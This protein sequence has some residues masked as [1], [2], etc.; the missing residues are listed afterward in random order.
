[1]GLTFPRQPVVEF[2]L[3]DRWRDVSLDVR[4]KPAIT[5]TQGR[6]DWAAK[7]SPAS[8]KF[9]LDDGPGH[10]DGDYDP[11]NPLGQWFGSFTR[12]VPVR[13]ALRYGADDFDRAVAAGWGT[14]PDMGAWTR[15][16]SAPANV[17]TDVNGNG[18][19]LVSTAA[20][21]VAQYLNDVSQKDID[22]AVNFA[23]NVATVTGGDLEP[24]NIMVRGQHGTL[25]DYYLVRCTINTSNQ[26]QLRIMSR[27]SVTLVGPVTVQS[28]FDGVAYTIRV[29]ADGDTLRTKLWP[30]L[31]GEPL[32]WDLEYSL[33]AA[34]T[35]FGA[36]W[37]GIR[38]GVGGGNTNTKPIIVNY[39]NLDVR[40]PRFAGETVKLQPSTTVDHADRTTS[41]EAAAIRRRLAK[42]EKPLFTA[43]RRYIE[44]GQAPFLVR[45][46]W[47]MDQDANSATRASDVLGGPDAR[48]IRGPVSG[49]GAFEY[50]FDTTFPAC[51]KAAQLSTDG[52]LAMVIEPTLFSTSSGW[53][54]TW[55]QKVGPN[56]K[57][58]VTV[59]LTNGT[60]LQIQFEGGVATMFVDAVTAFSVDLPEDGDDSSWHLIGV[61]TKQE[62]GD[63]KK[64]LAVDDRLGESEVAGTTGLP[65]QFAVFADDADNSTVQLSQVVVG[66]QYLFNFP[67]G[68]FN[69]TAIQ[70]L[71]LGRPGETAGTRLE[72]LTDEEGIADTL[73]GAATDTPAMGP[74]T[75]LPLLKLLD[76]CVTVDQGSAFDPR[77]TTGL[78][79]RTLRSTVTRDPV[80]TL[81]Y[82]SG[83]VAPD[84]GPITDDQPL[85]ND[86]TAKRP[87][88]GEVQVEQDEGPNN[89]NDPGTA[90]GAAGRA[91][92]SVT[93]NVETDSQLPD[94]ASWRVHMGTVDQPRYSSVTVDLAAPEVAS[95]PDLGSAVLDVGVDDRLDVTGAQSR[96]IFDDVR[97][98]V[99]GY[100]ETIG[101]QGDAHLHKIVFNTEPYAPLDVGAVDTDR[102][103][104]RN[105]TLAASIT[106]TATSFTIT[107]DLWTT[108]PDDFPMTV[109]VGGEAI[110]IT[111]ITG[112]SSPQTVTVDAGGRSVNGVVKDHAA[113]TPMQITRP[114]YRGT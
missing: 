1:M 76:E 72:R 112:S 78:G 53:M 21:Y 104:A 27:D 45:N 108:D 84:F 24:A 95:D 17:S 61:G 71:Y 19:H 58:F 52:R 69:Y 68:P 56:G 49:L 65:T 42:G 41:V 110:T 43:L 5:I 103:A 94:Q 23:V 2:Y 89:V 38:T 46:Y 16:T 40:L 6:K 39:D 44:R 107:G 81:D 36:G 29:Q 54:I 10:G 30:T 22:V 64:G 31:S 47:P 8:C 67:S 86:V 26:M 20:T 77:G 82:A 97:L 109:N 91:D 80:L 98:I 113:G 75:P 9:T 33:T 79:M 59:D 111:G 73:I 4:Q 34:D 13:L 114:V 3:A 105:T 87:Q 28:Y 57:A 50:G 15:F 35:R 93:T 66:D 63:F 18:R 32:G 37:V 25:T 74:Q 7:P 90:P 60:Q 14:S 70:D 101:D 62:G 92:T 88:G 85:L 51:P 55:L 102:W 83:H 12:S 100:T 96:R 48:F 99:R 106:S 11:Y